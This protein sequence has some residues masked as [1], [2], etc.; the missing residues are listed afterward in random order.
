M[1]TKWLLLG[2]ILFL[3]LITSGSAAQ[4]PV[5]EGEIWGR[6]INPE[7]GEPVEGILVVVTEEKIAARSGEDGAFVLGPLPL[8]R[9]KVI[10]EHPCFYPLSVEVRLDS[11]APRRRVSVGIPYDYETEARTGCDW[12]IGKPRIGDP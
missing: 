5:V 7:T 8:G 10:F 3:P 2:G 1:K 4:V 6:V 11:A 9:K 12:R